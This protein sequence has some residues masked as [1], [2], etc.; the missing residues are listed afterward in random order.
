MN[1]NSKR[2]F[3]TQEVIKTTSEGKWIK[4]NG[5]NKT[6]SKERDENGVQ[7][8]RL[9]QNT[10]WCTKTTGRSQLDGGDFYVYVTEK[11]VKF[12]QELQ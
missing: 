10:Y 6:T 7:L 5:G 9:V 2:V 11:M 4:F 1:E 3:K 8:M 12:S